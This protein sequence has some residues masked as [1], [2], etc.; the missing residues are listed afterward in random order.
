MDERSESIGGLKGRGVR[1]GGAGTLQV[2]GRRPATRLAFT[3]SSEQALS[4]RSEDILVS[5]R[6]RAEGFLPSYVADVH[7]SHSVH[8]MSECAT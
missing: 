1:A 5:D 7:T 6:E 3:W 2:V 4:E 8:E